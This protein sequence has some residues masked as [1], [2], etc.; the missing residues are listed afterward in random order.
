MKKNA[1]SLIKSE[2][3][4]QGMHCAAC[5]L[6]IEGEL[7][8]VKGV[9]KVKANLGDGKVYIDS[10]KPLKAS[11]LSRLVE[12]DGYYI[13]YE[14]AHNA[15]INYQELIKAAVIAGSI[16]T[17]FLLLEYLGIVNVLNTDK[18]SLPFVF[19][20]GVVAS[21]STC[22]AVVG[23]LVIS[24]SSTFAKTNGRIHIIAFHL[25]RLIGFFLLGGVIGLIGSAFVLT[26]TTSFILS[27]VLFI[28]MMIMGINLLELTT[29]TNKLQIRMPKFIGNSI[30]KLNRNSN[31]NSSKNKI[32]LIVSALLG[33]LT[34][35]LPCGFTQSMQVY[36][37]TTGS[38]IES[39]L[40]MFVF[41]LGTL[42]VL[43]IISFSSIK[44]SSQK[45]SKL[46]FKAAGF[47]V[48]FFALYNFIAAVKVTG[49]FN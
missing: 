22:M 18:V 5:Q 12:K 46:F 19:L 31:E 13:T 21:V 49:L 47:L 27:F 40:T 4:V 35:F 37:L 48:I 39:A 34:F 14:K 33:A 17:G 41:A 26:N 43:G 28:V 32:D 11:E 20:I 10:I 2:F 30:L 16:F 25:S 1:G 9:K 44:I 45:N 38:F 24:L 15:N 23:G 42:P 3:Y 36:S 7:Q 29:A 8:N 6:L